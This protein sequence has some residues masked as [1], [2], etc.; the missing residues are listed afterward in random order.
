LFT[1]GN[2][3]EIKVVITSQLRIASLLDLVCDRTIHEDS[4]PKVTHRFLCRL[5]DKALPDSVD[6]V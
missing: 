6:P 2:A 5:D 4:V 1:G 3:P